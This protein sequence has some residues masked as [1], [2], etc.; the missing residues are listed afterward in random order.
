VLGLFLGR[1]VAPAM[2]VALIA[3][4]LVGGLIMARLGVEKGRKTP[5]PFGPFLALG[6]LVGLLAGDAIVG[7]YL[8]TFV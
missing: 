2:M 3:G 7:W 8:D 1:N 4:T 5:V 6:A